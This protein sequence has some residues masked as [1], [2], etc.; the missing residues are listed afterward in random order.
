MWKP[1][2]MSLFWAH[3]VSF[4]SN[5]S[6]IFLVFSAISPVKCLVMPF[7][8]SL[9]TLKF[10]K[11]HPFLGN[12]ARSWW[13]RMAAKSI[14]FKYLIP[15]RPSSEVLALFSLIVCKILLFNVYLTVQLLEPGHLE[16]NWPIATHCKQKKATFFHK[17]TNNVEGSRQYIS[18]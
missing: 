18:K 14:Y 5:L 15:V 1:R 6:T 4:T 3:V 16:E 9:S 7:L 11:F 17:L 12:R 10:A 13:F 8:Y 2:I